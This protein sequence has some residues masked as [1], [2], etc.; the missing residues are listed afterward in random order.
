MKTI[1]L[2]LFFAGTLLIMHGIYDQRI[3]AIEKNK[4]IEYRF[5]PRT[6]L[7]EQLADSDISGKMSHMFTKESPW[8]EKNVTLA[9]EDRK[10][11]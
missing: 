8:F 1:V 4:R 3:K 2:F 6:Y 10:K 11:N 7:E 5:I 9:K